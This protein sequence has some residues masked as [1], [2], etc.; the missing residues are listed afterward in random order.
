M[1]FDTTHSETISGK[2]RA[3]GRLGYIARSAI[4][5]ILANKTDLSDAV[6]VY[7]P[8]GY[9]ELL[10]LQD[11][12]VYPARVISKDEKR[13]ICLLPDACYLSELNAP[14]NRTGQTWKMP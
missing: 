6:F 10:R 7:C 4:D 2:R 11:R 13:G 1:Y 8:T 12:F 5:A 3:A 9:L 14:V